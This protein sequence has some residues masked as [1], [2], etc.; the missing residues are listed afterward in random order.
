MLGCISLL[1]KKINSPK[2]ICCKSATDTAVRQMTDTDTIFKLMKVLLKEP[3][4]SYSDY[5][6]IFHYIE[7]KAKD[8]ESMDPLYPSHIFHPPTHKKKGLLFTVSTLHIT[9]EHTY[10]IANAK[11]DSC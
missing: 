10:T 2:I 8:L 5:D 6:N 11:K 3:E 4:N 9:T 7:S 1:V